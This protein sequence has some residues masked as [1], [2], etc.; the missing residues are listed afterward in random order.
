MWLCVNF[1]V[2]I[3]GQ[4]ETK[5]SQREIKYKN[6]QNSSPSYTLAKFLLDLEEIIWIRVKHDRLAPIE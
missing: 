2:L 5:S 3:K 1:N 6:K 4:C